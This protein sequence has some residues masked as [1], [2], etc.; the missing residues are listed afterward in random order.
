MTGVRVA[1][2]G[3]T[4]GGNLGNRISLEAGIGLLRRTIPDAQITVLADDLVAVDPSLG[5][6]ILRWPPEVGNPKHPGR[7]APLVRALRRV[8]GARAAG[9]Q[10]DVL[11]VPGTGLLEGAEHGWHAGLLPLAAFGA[12]VLR[13]GGRIVLFG[14]GAQVPSSPVVRGVASWL[15]SHAG[16]ASARDEESAQ[17]LA[18]LGRPGAPV[19]P[20][21]VFSQMPSRDVVGAARSAAPTAVVGVCGYHGEDLST[22]QAARYTASLRAAVAWLVERGYAVRVVTG[23][24]RDEPMAVEV[25]GAVTGDVRAV[26][27]ADFA[28]LLRAVA[29]ASVGMVTRFHNVVALL[30]MGVPVV[31]VGYGSKNDALLRA[32]GSPDL[33]LRSQSVTP[34][35]TVRSL[36][37]A[38]ATAAPRRA[39]IVGAVDAF[40]GEVMSAWN[41]ASRVIA[42]AITPP[43]AHR[44]VP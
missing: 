35:E 3:V 43:L 15:V 7:A 44:L 8:L 25:A 34:A 41:E 18:R 29:G 22:D 9:E 37:A 13:R 32:V 28:A 30:S 16:Y 17:A 42:P 6:D 10:Y 36:S 40:A 21:I 11:L 31:S 14:I 23:H 39:R 5:A 20:D 12:G 27:A 33:C 26:P 19:H 1:V 24:T 38:I 2:L 4:A